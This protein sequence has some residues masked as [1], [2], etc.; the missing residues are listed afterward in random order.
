VAL[1]PADLATVTRFR[2]DLIKRRTTEA[3]EAA[4]LSLTD[5][6]DALDVSRQI[7]GMWENGTRIPRAHHALAYARLLARCARAAAA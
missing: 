5:V 7:V 2:A 3:R 6:A 4:G 1:T